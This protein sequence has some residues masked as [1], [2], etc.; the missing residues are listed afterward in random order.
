M[1][2]IALI[3]SGVETQDWA[4]IA[5]AYKQLTGEDLNI[6]GVIETIPDT[7]PVP[8]VK[9]RGRPKKPKVSTK[10]TEEVEGLKDV[11]KIPDKMVFPADHLFDKGEAQINSKL[12]AKSV[13]RQMKKR[14]PHK[15][16]Y[17]A[18]PACNYGVDITKSF[19]FVGT[20]IGE[21]S[22]LPKYKCPNCKKE[23][24]TK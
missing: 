12:A 13:S 6:P 14:S 15:P 5:A 21:A 24:Q 3:K 4:S 17:R 2:A 10:D 7:P 18:C 1:N 20:T 9:K 11:T 19:V 8:T 16:V 23:F 22:E